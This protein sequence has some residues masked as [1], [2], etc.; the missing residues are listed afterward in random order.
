MEQQCE[1]CGMW[2]EDDYCPACI[3]QLIAQDSFC[4]VC[5]NEDCHVELITTY[6]G[7]V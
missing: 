4:A 7:E 5:N 2:I 6:F 1:S 3:E